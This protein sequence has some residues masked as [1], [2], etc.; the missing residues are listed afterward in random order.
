MAV[1]CHTFIDAMSDYRQCFWSVVM[2]SS[3]VELSTSSPPPDE[4]IFRF[5]DND[6]DYNKK[7][8]GKWIVSKAWNVHLDITKKNL[9]AKAFYE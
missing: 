4:K 6:I 5:D 9:K 2:S 3:D 8:D 1:K 7:N